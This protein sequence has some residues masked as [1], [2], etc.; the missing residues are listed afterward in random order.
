MKIN[1]FSAKGVHGYQD[2]EIDFF[3]ELTFLIGINGSGKTSV[4]KLILGLTSPSYNYLTNID[5]HH[6]EVICSSKDARKDIFIQAT[7]D[8]GKEKLY[9]V[10]EYN[11]DTFK[12]SFHITPKA[13]NDDMNYSRAN[14]LFFRSEV[15][16]NISKLLTPKY[17][18]LG[19]RTFREGVYKSRVRRSNDEVRESL[20]VREFERGGVLPTQIDISIEEIQTLI[21]D[22][23][24]KIAYEQSQISEEFKKKIISTSFDFVPFSLKDMVSSESYNDKKLNIKKRQVLKAIKSFDINYLDQD[25]NKYFSNLSQMISDYDVAS[26]KN[27]SND[28]KDDIEARDR[29]VIDL[30]FNIY[31]KSKQLNRLEGVIEQNKVSQKKLENLWSPITK[32][33]KIVNEY[34]KESKKTLEILPS[35]EIKILFKGDHDVDILNLS[36]GEKQIIIMIAHLVFYKSDDKS[37]ATFIID[38]P[39]L[40]LHMAWQEIFVDSILEASPKTQFILAT[41]SPS[42][43]S[44]PER[45][46]FCQDLSELNL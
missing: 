43:V 38:E 33:E 27:K 19:R 6:C 3:S 29:E 10:L 30:F 5:F 13:F 9:V 28:K 46:I 44:K 36:S 26:K 45:E 32:F 23:I 16:R 17:L 25:I 31:I 34:L 4:L 15:V 35:G 42:I 8:K 2:F 20:R 7:Q 37:I 1:S 22:F 40:S 24:R 11:G 41:H 14:A 21:N 18:G 39:E 12:N